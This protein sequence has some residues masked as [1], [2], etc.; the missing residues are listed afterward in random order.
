MAG[1]MANWTFWNNLFIACAIICDVV[2][3]YA[4]FP[5]S[6]FSNVHIF[7]SQ[8]SFNSYLKSST[9][10]LTSPHVAILANPSLICLAT[11][12]IVFP[13]STSKTFPSFNV[14]FTIFIPPL[15]YLKT[16]FSFKETKKHTYRLS[17][18]IG[19]HITR[20]HPIF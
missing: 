6:L 14:T 4:F 17:W 7:N 16:L 11:S 3:Q 18:S 2:C 13:F 20:F 8:S 9:F 1:P 10:P 19:V 15:G 5:S 12:K